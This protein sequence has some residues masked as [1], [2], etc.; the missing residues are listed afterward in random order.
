MKF[1]EQLKAGFTHKVQTPLEALLII[2]CAILAA[3]VLI[4]LTHMSAWFL[5]AAVLGGLYLFVLMLRFTT[6]LI[7]RALDELE[8][9]R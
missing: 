6:E 7:E 9:Q 4:S 1:D 3:L 2:V 5:V 8:E